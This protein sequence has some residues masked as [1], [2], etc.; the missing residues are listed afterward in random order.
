MKMRA[1]LAKVIIGS[2]AALC[3]TAIVLLI[4]SHNG[5]F[6]SRH[7]VAAKSISAARQSARSAT[8]DPRLAEAYGNLPMGFEENRGQT[9]S[10]V[11]FLSRGQGYQVFLTAQEAV[12]EVHNSKPL[13]F[14]PRHR[15]ASAKILA[16]RKKAA[17]TS[18]IRMRLAGANPHPLIAGLNQLPGKTNYFIGND[19]RKWQTDIPSFARVK[20][21]DVYPGV[22]LV[23]YGNHRKLEYDYIV[24]P[25]ADPKAIA[26]DVTGANK[27]R[28]D[29]Q[30]NLLMT[31]S[32]GE[33]ELQKP[34]VYQDVNGRREEVASNY[35]LAAGNRV[36]FSVGAYD[37]TKALTIDPTLNYSTYVGGSAN[38]DEA[39]GIAVDAAGDAYIAGLTYSATFP[40]TTLTAYQPTPTVATASF[41]SVFVTELN[42]GGTAEMYSTYLGGSGGELAY[43]VAV[44]TASPANVYVTGQTF[45]TDYPTTGNAYIPGPLG[46][47]PDGTAFV[48]RLNPTAS[49]NASL[50]YSSFVG[51]TDGDYGNAIAV[52]SSE[53]AYITGLTFSSG[54]NTASG[55]QTSPTDQVDGNAF[56][57]E[58]DT[59]A[60][61]TLTYSTYLGG[62]GANAGNLG[63][64]DQGY[65]IAVSA[66]TAYIIGTTSSLDFPIVNGYQTSVNAGNDTGTVF[67]SVINTAVSG[68]AGL[69]YSTY[70]SGESFDDGYSIAQLSGVAYATGVTFSSQ[71]PITTGA[72]QTTYLGAG[73]DTAFVSLIDTTLSGTSSLKYSTYLGGSNGDA[74]QGIQVDSAGNAYVA[75]ATASIGSTYVFP[76]TPGAL[77]TTSANTEG[78]AF[79]TEI[80]PLG[81]GTSDLIYSTL[82]GGSGNNGTPDRAFGIALD[83]SNNAYI[84]G[85]TASTDFPVYPNPG[86]FQTSLTGSDPL[87][88]TAAFAVKLTLVPTVTVTPTSLAFGTVLDGTTSPAQLV[89]I[90]NNT[91]LSN[92]TYTLTNQTGNT[93]DFLAVPGG[94]TPCP[95]G[96]LP[97]SNTPCTISVTF[98]PST[99]GPEATNLIV[100]YN[101][102]GIASSQTVALSGNGT[103]SA[104]SVAPS[105]FTFPTGQLVTTTSSPTTITITNANNSTLAFT[106]GSTDST[107]FTIAPGGTT[108]CSPSAG[109]PANSSCTYTATLNPAVGDTGPLTT[110]FSVNAN[111]STQTVVL[112]GIGW[113]FNFSAGSSQTIS[114]TPG[115]TIT[116]A[117]TVTINFLGGFPGPVALACS[118][119]IPLGSCTVTSSVSSSGGTSATVPVTITT[120]G[121]SVAPPSSFRFPPV[122]R[123]QVV[124]LGFSILLL[125]SLPFMRRRRSR[126]GLVGA[127]VMIVGLA[128]C[129][130]SSGTPAGTYPLTITASSNGRVQSSTITLDVK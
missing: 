25:G 80:A 121:S 34:V 40:T 24:A 82:F 93:G 45:S 64:A 35:S 120:K 74:G 97:A 87:A 117:P 56:L 65:G 69:T 60:A 31:V 107:D 72:F 84:G 38:G 119:S 128:A 16:A 7:T 122:S 12:L 51:G 50:V 110:T 83:S 71:F 20:Y 63:F 70:L 28:I 90:T 1:S 57:T 118:G 37:R 17:A 53:N 114:T 10:E 76:L 106:T 81:G 46:S 21:A 108:P 11:R 61:G 15:A 77:Q 49:G 27:L 32:G 39:F 78:V 129:S 75:G 123:R 55:Y 26:L 4:A 9:N 89:T 23:F 66:G 58:V 5:K 48:T 125:F 113:D 85:Q 112:N 68:T 86:A 91:G 6:A 59:N 18:V 88:T 102:Y 30:G 29:A 52:D 100:G 94:G 116:P 47:N 14:S 36:N 103:T 95:A 33:V 41:G 54:I 101:P 13:D 130:G 67:V 2:T 44:D 92:I 124:L 98:S 126:V 111:S 19:S 96:T 109:I 22:D 115:A 104:F 42:P 99:N 3:I 8:A 73:S 105:N 62:S 43:G 127:V 79:V